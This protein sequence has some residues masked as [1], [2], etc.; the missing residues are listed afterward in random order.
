MMSASSW[1]KSSIA[2]CTMPA[3]S[4]SP[5]A[6]SPSSFFLLMSLGG[7]VAE[8]IAAGLAQ[9]FAPIVHNGAERALAG[10]VADEA[11]VVLQLDIVAVDIDGGQPGRAVRRDG[12]QGRALIG[13]GTLS[14]DKSRTTAK[15]PK[16]FIGAS[17]GAPVRAK[18]CRDDPLHDVDRPPHQRHRGF[19]R[20]EGGMGG[21]RHVLHPRQGMVGLERLG[22]KNVEA[23]MADV[24][25]L[26]RVDEGRFV[27]KRA[28]R[29]VDQDHAGLGAREAL[30]V[31]ETAGLIVERKMQR[32]HVGA[33]QQ[34]VEI[35]QRHAGV[36][37]RASGSRRSPPCRCRARCAPPPG[38]CRRAR[39][40]R[41]SCR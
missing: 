22:M 41:A 27:D 36:G 4:G 16:S 25:A 21:E 37:A 7:L 30:R 11:F 14:R 15:R 32:D 10:A 19:Q 24:A 29:G 13:H 9:R 33:R 1:A 20:A 39:S 38:R 6:S 23:G 3:A 31:E 8:G 26:E 5:S 12:R 28:A 34:L 18:W 40:G 2:P 17:P 35:D